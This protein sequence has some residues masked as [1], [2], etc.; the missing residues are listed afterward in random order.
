M[1][2]TLLQNYTQRPE[3]QIQM[4]AV[5][6]QIQMEVVV[7]NRILREALDHTG[8]QNLIAR[9][10]SDAPSVVTT[11][12]GKELTNRMGNDQEFAT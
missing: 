12:P 5:I 9:H 11:H 6:I 1:V 3:R 8:E 4:E 2:I 10:P 7:G